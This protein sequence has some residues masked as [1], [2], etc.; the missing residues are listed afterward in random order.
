MKNFT[1]KICVVTG[2]GSG[3]GRATAYALGKQG[4]QLILTDINGKNVKATA[5]T[6]KEQGGKADAHIIDAA[7]RDAAFALADKVKKKYGG[8]DFILNNAGVVNVGE[9]QRLTMDDF[10]FVMDIDFWGVVHGTQA[11]LPHMLEKNSGHIANISS[12]FGLIGVPRQAAY[13]SAKF[14]VLGFTEAL[15]HDLAETNIGVSC[16]HPGGIDTNIARNARL[17]QE[18]DTEET[19]AEFAANFKEVAK[20]TPDKAAQVILKGVRKNKARI[21]IGADAYFIEWIVRLFPTRY[22]KVL[23]RFLGLTGGTNE[24][25][26]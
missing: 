14:A 16:I 11:F 23:N 2:A 15:R 12:V 5:T 21:L 6:I 24:A 22:N 9:V 8:A 17:I 13:N 19:R 20:T 26:N 7:D 4:A 10:N 3:I 25:Q 18:E 1:D